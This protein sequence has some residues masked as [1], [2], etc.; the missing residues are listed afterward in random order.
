MCALQLHVLHF[1]SLVTSGPSSSEQNTHGSDD[2][3]VPP[4]IQL[5]EEMQMQ[6]FGVSNIL[7]SKLGRVS[8]ALY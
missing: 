4:Q 2:L 3:N 1:E 5:S 7:V 6:I 8:G